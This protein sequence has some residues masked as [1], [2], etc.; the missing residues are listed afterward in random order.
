MYMCETCGK[1]F[2]LHQSVIIHITYN[3]SGNG[4][5]LYIGK[6]VRS[7][8]ETDGVKIYIPRDILDN[9]DAKPGDYYVIKKEKDENGNSSHILY[10]TKNHPFMY[11][12]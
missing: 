7:N 3:H 6:C 8:K 5:Y 12:W 10:F 4:S 2:L 1:T 11:K 9:Y